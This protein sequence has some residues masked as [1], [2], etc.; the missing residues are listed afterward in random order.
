MLFIKFWARFHDI[1]DAH[2]RTISSYSLALMLIHYLQG[3]ALSVCLSAHPPIHLPVR[4]S[5][6]LCTP[7]L[8][9][10]FTTCRVRPSSVGQSTHPSACPSICLY[11]LAITLLH[12]LQGEAFVCPS[13]HPSV[14]LPVCPS[15]C[16]LPCRHAYPLP[17]G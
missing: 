16:V 11:S 14:Y 3:E 10:L 15:V 13:A 7:W 17:A 5:V 9:C 8:S 12:Y 1:N 2:K 6:C 4:P